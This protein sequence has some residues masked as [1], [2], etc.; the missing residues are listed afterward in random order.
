M[1]RGFGNQLRINHGDVSRRHAS[2]RMEDDY[3]LLEDLQSRNGTFVNGVRLAPGASRRLQDSDVLQLASVVSM[4][5]VD[6][7]VT[8]E[9]VEV[10]PLRVRGLWLDPQAQIVMVRSERVELPVQQY[11]LLAL[12]YARVGAVVSRQ[13]IAD[14]LWSTEAELT[15]QMIDNTIS[16]LRANLQRVDTEHDYIVTVR[17]FGY[18][19]VQSK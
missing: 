16:R 5:F 7:Y 11:R 10:R 2:V 6:P 4:V 1:G 17:G 3:Y 19:F 14:A 9:Q 13:E 12:L 8:R 18:Q 15:A